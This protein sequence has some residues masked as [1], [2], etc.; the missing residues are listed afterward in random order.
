M[1]RLKPIQ[2]LQHSNKHK[3]EI[4]TFIN[5]DFDYDKRNQKF[6]TTEGFRSYYSLN[7]PIISDKN[8][9]TNTYSYNHFSELYEDNISNF[10]IY[11]KAANSL[12]GEDIKL[13]ERL[14]IPSSKLRGFEAGK[15]G[16]KDGEDYVG[17]NYV[18]TINFS[19]TLP[20]LLENVQQMDLLVFFDA[21]NIWGVDYS[22]SLSDS[23]K[24][25][26]SFG[27]GIDWFT[28]IGPLN[29]SLS[30]PISKASTDVTET[31]RFNLGTTF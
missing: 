23:S 12:T 5:F 18:S 20:A 24:I 10:S 14:Y 29:F 1:K 7:L 19:S 3:K 25:R 27:I 4:D 31:F 11:L 13:S 30:Q 2:Q 9:L 21:A 22:S 8:T 26:S 6:Q 17:G 16:P 28:P 15:V